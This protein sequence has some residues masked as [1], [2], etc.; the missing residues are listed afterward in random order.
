MNFLCHALPYFDRPVQAACTGVPD[1][2]S[3]IDRKIR[4]RRK[5]ALPYLESADPLMAELASGIVCHVEDDQWFHG[6]ELFTRLNLEFAVQLRQL[7]P[8]DEGFRPSFVG[9]I[10]IEMLLDANY[11]AERRDWVDQYYASI[12]S[13]P[14]AAVQTRL[15]TLTGKP[16]G[17]LEETLRRFAALRFLYDYEDDA[18]LL[19]RINQVLARVRLTP[20]PDEV[21]R[22]IAEARATVRK[23]H[24]Q[25][26]TPPDRP[27]IHPPL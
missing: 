13:L 6:S 1:W 22:W 18:R 7:L 5:S 26:L 17:K 9:H 27:T 15:N 21:V 12:E 4:A 25:L 14:A 10:V 16:T 3:V 24:Q 2:L 23:H 8:G 19:F 20:L 11:V